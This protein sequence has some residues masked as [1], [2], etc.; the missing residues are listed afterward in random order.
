VV[1]DSPRLVRYL[2]HPGIG[3]MIGLG[4]LEMLV[5]DPFEAGVRLLVFPLTPTVVPTKEN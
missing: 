4:T 2:A 5:A 1:D 3:R